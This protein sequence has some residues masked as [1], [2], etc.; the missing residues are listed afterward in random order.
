MKIHEAL[1]KEK[2]EET[3]ETREG[4]VVTL[5]VREQEQ[6]SEETGE[7]DSGEQE[8]DRPINQE[9]N[10]D[11]QEVK[12]SDY[13]SHLDQRAAVADITVD[14]KQEQVGEQNEVVSLQPL[15]GDLKE[16]ATVVDV[17]EERL[18]NCIPLKGRVNKQKH[19]SPI[20]ARR[21]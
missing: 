1:A 17:H 2:R 21:V 11:K 5:S 3:E 13:H 4:G 6:A 10:Q 7:V 9:D 15:A 18:S 12:V 16:E 8:V 20:L 14:P 19:L